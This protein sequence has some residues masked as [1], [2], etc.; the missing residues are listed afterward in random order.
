MGLVSR[1]DI[2]KY[3]HTGGRV[4]NKGTQKGRTSP[5][6]PPALLPYRHPS[7]PVSNPSQKTVRHFPPWVSADCLRSLIRSPPV[8]GSDIAMLPTD[9][10]GTPSPPGVS[11]QVQPRLPNRHHRCPPR[12]PHTHGHT[13]KPHVWVHVSAMSL[14]PLLASLFPAAFSYPTVPWSSHALTHAAPPP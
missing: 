1:D 5:I 11:L 3:Y 9:P 6:A 12:S 14:S 2:S 13:V 7:S 4:F 8:S 10:C